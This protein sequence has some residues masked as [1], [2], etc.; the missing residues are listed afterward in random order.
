MFALLILFNTEQKPPG[1]YHSICILLA[2]KRDAAACR[3]RDPLDSFSIPFIRYG[4]K[5][6]GSYRSF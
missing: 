5:K 3:M 1:T 6:L 2:F 4:D